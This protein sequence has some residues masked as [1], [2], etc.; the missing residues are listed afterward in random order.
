VKK[1]FQLQLIIFLSLFVAC[2]N[3]GEQ[4]V[5]GNNGGNIVQKI[6]TIK[7]ESN[8]FDFGTITSG[9]HVSHRFKFKNTGSEN[10]Y[11]NK[12][13]ASCGCTVV[14]YSKEA[15]LPGVESYIE[16]V[17]DSSSYHGLQIKDITVYANTKPEKIELVVAATVD[18]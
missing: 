14:N 2:D 3:S 18:I 11:I 12:V 9:E 7:F 8:E 16:I 15:V 5:Q 17:F 6:T 1:V 10:L 4:Q 13:E